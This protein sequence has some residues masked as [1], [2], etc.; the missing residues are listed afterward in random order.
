[1][2]DMETYRLLVKDELNGI[3]GGRGGQ[4]A[5]YCSA[6]P[7]GGGAVKSLKRR[8]REPSSV[9]TVSKEEAGGDKSGSGNAAKGSSRFRGV[10]R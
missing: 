4:G 2:A 10:S 7:K 5:P 6:A 8:K 1:M 9:V 3:G